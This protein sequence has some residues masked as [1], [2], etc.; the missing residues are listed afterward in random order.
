LIVDHKAPTNM[1]GLFLCEAAKQACLIVR[2]SMKKAKAT[3]RVAFESFGLDQFGGRS[4]EQSGA[5]NPNPRNIVL[6]IVQDIIFCT[7]DL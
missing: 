2:M 4:A 7:I 3:L 5:D 1:S 6:F